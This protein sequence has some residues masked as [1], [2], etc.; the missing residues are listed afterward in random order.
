[1]G[2]NPSHFG[3]PLRPVERV[4]WVDVQSF[5]QAMSMRG[6]GFTYRLP[7]EAEWEYSARAVVL[8]VVGLFIAGVL[9]LLPC[10]APGVARAWSHSRLRS[11]GRRP[12]A[13]VDPVRTSKRASEQDEGGERWFRRN[14]VTQVCC[15]PRL[16]R[17]AYQA[18]RSSR[19]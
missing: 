14:G 8:G 16:E 15:R 6:D 18:E 12:R 11:G 3:G 7:T 2:R 4:S 5:L 17:V 1:M 10:S 19:I 9:A 13:R